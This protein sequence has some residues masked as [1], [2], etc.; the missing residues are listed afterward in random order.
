MNCNYFLLMISFSFI[1]SSCATTKVTTA[2]SKTMEIYGAGVIQQP[3]V[4]ELEVKET[5]VNGTFTGSSSSTYEA[6][7]KEAVNVA[8]KQSKADVLVEPKF[9]TESINGKTKVTVYGFPGY[10]TKFRPMQPG[11]ELLLNSG[12]LQ[13]A[14]VYEPAVAQK[15]SS[16]SA[17]VWTVVLLGILVGAAVLA[18]KN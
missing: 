5:K 15:K 6:M 14:H 17:V 7:K 13:K 3:V 16:A 8:M 12:I 18:K 9:E 4:A 10:Y 11:D 1:L 2:T